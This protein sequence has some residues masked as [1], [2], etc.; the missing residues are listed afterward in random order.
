MKIY[1]VMR[2]TGDY[3][4]AVYSPVVAYE[5]EI[6]GKQ[7]VKVLSSYVDAYNSFADGSEGDCEKK[8][9]NKYMRERILGKIRLVDKKFPDDDCQHYSTLWGVLGRGCDALYYLEECELNHIIET[10][11]K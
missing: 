1:I 11:V 7:T 9:V 5:K 8:K 10:G 2:Q 4:D 6:Y 3:S